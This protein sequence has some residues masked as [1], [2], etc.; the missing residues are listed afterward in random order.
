MWSWPQTEA[1]PSVS[2]LVTSGK[3]GI[4]TVAKPRP[5]TAAAAAANVGGVAHFGS[6]IQFSDKQRTF[7]LRG[8]TSDEEMKVGTRR[9][10][11][12]PFIN[13]P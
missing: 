12:G 11:K 2:A 1:P 3:E 9:E 13:Q 5:L 8:S 10:A 4:G 7:L 6:S